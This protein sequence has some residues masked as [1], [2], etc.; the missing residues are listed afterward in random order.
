MALNTQE[1]ELVQW[2]KANGKDTS[3]ILQAL[4]R[5]RNEASQP[6]GREGVAGFATGAAKG[7]LRSAK[8]VGE[9]PIS[10]LSPVMSRVNEALLPDEALEP[11][12]EAERAGEKAAFVGE[13]A[14]GGA[15]LAR[16]AL[17]KLTK[18]GRD[19]FTDRGITEKLSPKLGAKETRL[20]IDEGRVTQGRTNPL[21]GKSKDVV[22][23]TE[24]VQRASEVVVRDIPNASRE[25]SFAL[26]E[27]MKKLI[28]RKATE[29]KPQ[30]TQVKFSDD[31]R[32]FLTKEWDDLMKIQRDSDVWEDAASSNLKFQQKFQRFVDE[33]I[34]ADNM[35]DLWDLR[36]RYDASITNSI[37]QANPNSAVSTQIKNEMWLQNRSVLNDIIENASDGLGDAARNSF[38]D[39]SSLYAGRNNIITREKIDL[40]GK[41]GLINPKNIVRFLIG[42][43]ATAIGV[44]QII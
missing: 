6:T 4:S 1:T 33:A 10:P 7:L 12:S 18:G 3:E 35:D 13:I 34:E 38:D 5:L 24:K 23:P 2:G 37:K 20:A 30:M 41:P 27:D 9:L 26:A 8:E 31:G 36:K 32:S 39:M 44:N 22:I 19:F 21:T 28:S 15:G 29:L 16:K 14:T 17:T 11:Q 43:G 25:S 40:K 42:A